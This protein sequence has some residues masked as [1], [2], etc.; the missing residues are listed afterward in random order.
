M[1]NYEG[2]GVYIEGDLEFTFDYSIETDKLVTNN[3]DGDIEWEQEVEVI[4]DFIKC[5]D[6]EK[7]CEVVLTDEQIEELNNEFKGREYEI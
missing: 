4:G 6:I 7:E 1:K 2:Q 5:Y 3:G